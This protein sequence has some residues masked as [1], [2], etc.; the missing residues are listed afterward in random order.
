MTSRSHMLVDHRFQAVE[1]LLEDRE[2]AIA[3]LDAEN[4]RT[5][6]DMLAMTSH[7]QAEHKELWECVAAYGAVCCTVLLL[8]LHCAEQFFEQGGATAGSV[9][10]AMRQVP[11]ALAG[12]NR[13]HRLRGRACVWAW[14][15]R[16]RWQR[17][18]WCWSW[19]WLH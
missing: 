13:E 10:Y 8:T 6:S 11:R 3:A 14:C 2:N 16:P 4:E 9:P 7:S 1:S 17:G 15:G 12:H 18:S 5:R 19:C